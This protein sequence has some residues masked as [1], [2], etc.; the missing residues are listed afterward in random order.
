M[1]FFKDLMCDKNGN[2]SSKRL[3]SFIAFAVII[4]GVEMN[5][6][7][8]AKMDNQF[9]VFLVSVVFG[10]SGMATAENMAMKPTNVNKNSKV[11]TTTDKVETETT[12][13]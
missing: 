5:L 7:H 13:P 9:L 3:M 4:Q 12:K 2:A 6:F 1:N 10:L 8:G 11:T